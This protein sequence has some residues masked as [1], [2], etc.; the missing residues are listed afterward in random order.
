MRRCGGSGLDRR[1]ARAR[2]DTRIGYEYVHY[3]ID[4][5]TRLASAEIHPDERA[6]TCAGFCAGPATGSPRTA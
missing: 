1:R 4:D 3:A 5:H 2:A 6:D